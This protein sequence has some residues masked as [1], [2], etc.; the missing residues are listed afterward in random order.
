M[1]A[2]EFVLELTSTPKK[3]VLVRNS[4]RKYVRACRLSPIYIDKIELAVDEAVSNAIEH[5][6]PEQDDGLIQIR[7]W[8]ERKRLF[9]AIRDFGKS[10]KP[11]PVNFATIRKVMKN[12][13]R[14]GMGRYLMKECMDSVKYVSRPQKYNETVMYKKIP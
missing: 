3:L 5:A 7:A 6:Y 14:R 10:Y 2:K 4:I 12:H 9:V 11:K 13:A 1:S 8:K